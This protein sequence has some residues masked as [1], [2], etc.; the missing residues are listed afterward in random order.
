MARHGMAGRGKGNTGA[1][2]AAPLIAFKAGA[3]REPMEDEKPK[4]H[5][6]NDD[7]GLHLWFS[8]ERPMKVARY[9]GSG[10]QETVYVN[11][12]A[13]KIRLPRSWYDGIIPKGECH[14]YDPCD[15]L[16]QSS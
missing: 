4:I 15:I 8:V 3:R 16:A 7:D 6:T 14:T 11:K 13:Q 10:K 12:Y 5:L 2:S 1:A 9:N